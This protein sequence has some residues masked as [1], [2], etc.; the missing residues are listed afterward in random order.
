MVFFDSQPD[1][2]T[3]RAIRKGAMIFI[4]ADEF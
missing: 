2:Q 4:S 3:A 1:K